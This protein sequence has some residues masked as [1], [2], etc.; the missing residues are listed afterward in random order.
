[1]SFASIG[2]ILVQDRS[3]WGYVLPPCEKDEKH[4]SFREVQ[5]SSA[6]AI[7]LMLHGSMFLG[8]LA[9]ALLGSRASC[10]V[11]VHSI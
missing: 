5:S 2:L 11:G 3:P 8:I 9:A 10:K 7:R 1:M 4:V 6:R